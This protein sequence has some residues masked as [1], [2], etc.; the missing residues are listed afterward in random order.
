[1]A[2]ETQPLCENVGPICPWYSCLF[3]RQTTS[4][5][6]CVLTCDRCS[7][8]C[9]TYCLY[10]IDLQN[11]W[12]SWFCSLHCGARSLSLYS[13]FTAAVIFG[14]DEVLS[15][16]IVRVHGEVVECPCRYPNMFPKVGTSP[17]IN[18]GIG[19]ANDVARSVIYHSLLNLLQIWSL[20][21]IPLGFNRC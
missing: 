7:V 6:N 11:Q 13:W 20:E 5:M 16:A 1:M 2:M 3:C 10:N 12:K 18:E 19:A 17:L 8:R 15:T 9:H 14:E 21:K 4:N